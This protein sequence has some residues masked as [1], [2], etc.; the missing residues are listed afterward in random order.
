M[1][2]RRENI[3]NESDTTKPTN[4]PTQDLDTAS[5]WLLFCPCWGGDEN[6]KEE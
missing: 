2:K 5:R 1:D 3:K 6:I 4:Q